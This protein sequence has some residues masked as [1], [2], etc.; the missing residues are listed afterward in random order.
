[1][2][3]SLVFLLVCLFIGLA[4]L[5]IKFTTLPKGSTSLWCCDINGG[6]CT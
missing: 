2:S 1:M 5:P 3:T 4:L 6:L